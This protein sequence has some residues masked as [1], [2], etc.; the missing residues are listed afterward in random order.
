MYSTPVRSG[1]VSLA[2]KSF[3]IPEVEPASY[4]GSSYLVWTLASSTLETLSRHAD[5]GGRNPSCQAMLAEAKKLHSSY[6]VKVDLS[7]E[8]WRLENW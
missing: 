3:S 4:P 1:E 6:E 7:L 5:E 8:S 2:A